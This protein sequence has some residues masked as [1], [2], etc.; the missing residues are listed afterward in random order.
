[1]VKLDKVDNLMRLVQSAQM[2]AAAGIATPTLAAQNLGGS[3]LSDAIARVATRQA[4]ALAPRLMTLQNLNVVSYANLTWQGIRGQAEQVVS[5]AD[6]AEG[7][8]GRPDVARAAAVELEN[9]RSIVACLHAEFSAIPA[10]LRLEWSSTLS[11]FDAAPNLRNLASLPRWAEIAYLDRRQMQTYV[12]WLF[13]QVQ[14]SEAKATALINDVIR[15]ALLLASHAPVDRII[16][17][18]MAR[19]LTGVGVGVHILMTVQE[20]AKLRFGMQALLYRGADLIARAKV[21]DIGALEVTAEVIH[22]SSV[23]VDLGSDVRIHFD[24]AAS[25]SLAGASVTRS[26]FGR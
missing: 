9:M 20:P 6:L 23:K 16:S 24:N 10:V 2:R 21:A 25:V 26:L 19:P 12:D 13:S 8:H 1:L 3:A 11:E 4:E 22:T 7:S 15:M 17:G 5:F 18:R 14:V